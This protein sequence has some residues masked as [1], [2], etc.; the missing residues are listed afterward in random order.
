[1]KKKLGN[2]VCKGCLT[3]KNYVKFYRDKST[4][5]GF[6]DACMVC[7]RG[8]KQERCIS[9]EDKITQVMD[10]VAVLGFP[11]EIVKE[12]V[13]GLSNWG[14]ETVED[15]TFAA[16]KKA[17]EL[18]SGK[19]NEVNGEQ[20]KVDQ[21]FS[22]F[23]CDSGLCAHGVPEVEFADFEEEDPMSIEE[24]GEFLLKDIQA[25]DERVAGVNATI[26]KIKGISNK[27]GFLGRIQTLF[28]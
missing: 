4:K 13:V 19:L 22:E 21:D 1:M 25:F 9:Q 28:T 8:N 18:A 20:K 2:K 15:L 5:D 16:V 7:V 27:K 23:L 6:G 11:E 12:S 17:Q 26:E 14:G 24:Q 10:A 3:I